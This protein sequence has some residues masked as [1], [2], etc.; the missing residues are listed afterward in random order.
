[1]NVISEHNGWY[2]NDIISSF[3]HWM[4]VHMDFFCCQDLY[5]ISLHQFW[6]WETVLIQ[7]KRSLFKK[8]YLFI[9]S[10]QCATTIA[11]FRLVFFLVFLRSSDSLYPLV[12]F[13]CS[14]RSW[15]LDICSSKNCLPEKYYLATSLCGNFGND[16][17]LQQNEVPS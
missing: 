6:P 5:K 8:S 15:F 17:C 13:E 4:M 14:L 7:Q 9:N 12:F 2:N 16:N 10:I 1:M 11:R 3:L